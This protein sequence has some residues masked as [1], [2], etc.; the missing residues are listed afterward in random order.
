MN[1][2]D[3][4]M[5]MNAENRAVEDFLHWRGALADLIQAPQ[6]EDASSAS[7]LDR[8]IVAAALEKAVE[9]LVEPGELSLWSHTVHFREDIDIEEGHE[10]LLTQFLFEIS[11][12]EVFEV[13]TPDL[14]HRWP[15]RFRTSLATPAADE[16]EGVH[17]TG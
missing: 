13:I 14:C 12:P 9:G 3:A 4:S 1:S 15:G 10:D 2:A 7:V 17:P 11:T 16:A 5:D 8:V 6:G